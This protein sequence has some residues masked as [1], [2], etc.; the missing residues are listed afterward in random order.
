MFYLIPTKNGIGVQI[1]GTYDD[2]R[3]VYSIIGNFWNHEEYLNK[4]GFDNRDKLISGFSYELR[5]AYEGSKLK[6]Q[7]S[8]FSYEKSEHFGCNISWVHFLFTLSSLRHNMIYLEANKLELSI[9]LQLEYWLERSMLKYD[10]KGG[11]NLKNYISG[12]IYGANDCIYQFMRTT[13][14]NFFRLGGGKK[15]FRKLPELLKMSI[16]ST[17]EYKQYLFKLKKDAAHLNCQPEDLEI[18]DSDID[19]EKVKW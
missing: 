1:W 2:L 14:A 19:Y 18:E 13:N 7:N 15:S 10:E 9:F 17:D 4:S 12:A 16:Y 6:R 11:H 5:K 8:H 3:T